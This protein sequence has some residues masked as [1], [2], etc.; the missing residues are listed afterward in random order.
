MKRIVNNKKGIFFSLS[1][2]LLI[3]FLIIFF[4]NK[5]D[6]IEDRENFRTERAQIIA[7]DHFINDFNRYYVKQ[8][9]SNSIKPALINRTRNVNPSFI[10]FSK[11]EFVNITITGNNS[12]I[13]YLKPKQTTKNNF[14][15]ALRTLTFTPDVAIFNYTLKSVEQPFFDMI[16]LN[17]SVYYEFKAFDTRWT[18]HIDMPI[19]VD[20]YG[21]YHPAYSS[22]VHEV[23][24][25]ENWV[26]N[27][28][29]SRCFFQ[30]IFK[31]DA[32]SCPNPEGY[33]IVPDWTP[34]T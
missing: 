31:P 24:N 7:M 8:I 28:T 15:Q 20:I 25:R 14:E 17:F 1:A 3:T 5:T 23:I 4:N 13:T 34:P 18:K 2:A 11:E 9:L 32:G 33:N 29:S 10:K 19:D 16:K 21:L 27:E 26:E 30:D 6:M 12:G 22:E